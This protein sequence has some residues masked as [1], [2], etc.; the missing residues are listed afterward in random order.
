MKIAKQRRKTDLRRSPGHRYRLSDLLIHP[1]VVGGGKEQTVYEML[2]AFDPK[3]HS[4][5]VMAFPPLGREK[6]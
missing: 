4:G 6:S 3:R 5:E 2:A 1:R